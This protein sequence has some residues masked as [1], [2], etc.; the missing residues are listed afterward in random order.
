[1]VIK[2][3]A[4]T[5]ASLNEVNKLITLIIIYMGLVQSQHSIN[6]GTQK[7]SIMVSGPAEYCQG[8]GSKH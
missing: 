6:T 4:W 8:I 1:M 7:P 2:D 5:E 3:G